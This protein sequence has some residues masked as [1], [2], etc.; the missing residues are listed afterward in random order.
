MGVY[1][2][3]LRV[4]KRG[5]TLAECEDASSVFPDAG[6]DVWLTDPVSVALSDGASE[7]LLAGEWASLL[8]E[9]VVGALRDDGRALRDRRVFADVLVDAGKAWRGWVREYVAN[10]RATGRPI[11]WYEQ[12]KLDR[13]PYATLLAARFEPVADAIAWR[14]AAL[15]DTCLFQTRGGRLL[16]AFPL[17][18]HREFTSSPGLVNGYNQD[19]ALV[20]RHVRTMS[21]RAEEGDQFFLCTD[22]LAAWFLAETER[23]GQPWN[24]L[25]DFTR[26]G[27]VDEF[28]AWLDDRRSAGSMANDDVTVVHVDLG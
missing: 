11:M 23:G 10:R 17:E 20:A 18:S 26:S 27:A 21:G 4:P 28:E 22:A 14:A 16:H 5:S 15:G 19:R 7:S 1:V 13:G 3:A 25:C 2:S 6:S 9:S 8:A 12:P 24:A